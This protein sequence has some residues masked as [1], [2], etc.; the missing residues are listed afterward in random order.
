M[1]RSDNFQSRVTRRSFS[2]GAVALLAAPMALRAQDQHK[3]TLWKDGDPGER[4]LVSGRIVGPDN[5]PVGGAQIHV[6]QA[7]GAG[8]YTSDYSTTLVSAPDGKYELRT[9]LPGQ[10]GPAKHIH[11]NIAHPDY[12]PVYTEILFKLNPKGTGAENEILLEEARF[13]GNL[14]WVGTFNVMLEK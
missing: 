13:G 11:V 7:N 2:I 4:L 8:V 3:A 9:A 14:V 10:Y 12:Q 5:K 6:R 1:S